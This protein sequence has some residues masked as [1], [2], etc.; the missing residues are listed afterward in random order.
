MNCKDR[1]VTPPEA[2]IPKIS[3]IELNVDQIIVNDSVLITA[4][5][6]E[7]L[8]EEYVL[9]WNLKGYQAEIDSITSETVFSWKAPKVHGSY[10]HSVQ[11]VSTTGEPISDS[12]LFSTE[13]ASVPVVP[14]EGNKLVLI[15][16][17]IDGT[18][19]VFSMNID[20]SELEQ[21]TF[22]GVDSEYPSWSPDGKHIVFTSFYKGTSAGPVIYLMNSD[23]TNLRA[24]KPSE[25]S[26]S[27]FSG[28]YPKWSPDGTMITFSSSGFLDDIMIYDFEMDSVFQLT[29]HSADDQHPNWS[30]ESELVVFASKRDYFDAD[31]MRYRSDLYTIDVNGENLQRLTETGFAS[32]PNWQ[33]NNKHIAFEWAR[34]GNRVFY[35]DLSSN[36]IKELETNLEFEGFAKWSRSNEWLFIMGRIDENANPEVQMYDFSQNPPLLINMYQDIEAFWNGIDFDWY[37]YEE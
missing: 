33:Y 7:E 31:S 34:H 37:H 13:I 27:G 17:A 25:D 22:I 11:V 3:G 35:L 28:G 19:E 10:E 2:T 14:V 30:P 24:M 20:G 36:E 29:N 9:K 26:T 18:N 8:G 6:S 1:S 32:R 23:G 21:L 16:P 15:M 5:L 4:T 12:Y